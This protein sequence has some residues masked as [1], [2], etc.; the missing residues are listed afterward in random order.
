MGGLSSGVLPGGGRAGRRRR[1]RS[2]LKCVHPCPG[3]AL[4]QI[5]APRRR[6]WLRA[7]LGPWPAATR[8]AG[9]VRGPALPNPISH[10]VWDTA[11]VTAGPILSQLLW[12]GEGDPKVSGADPATLTPR[13]VVGTTGQ[14][15]IFQ[16][17]PTVK[18]MGEKKTESF[19]QDGDHNPNPSI[20][21]L[22]GECEKRQYMKSCNQM[23]NGIKRRK[24]YVTM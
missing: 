19:K 21:M 17:D 12:G 6:P 15:Q 18:L 20:P 9:A 2:L 4:P 10:A 11:Q 22:G 3:Q 13:N 23:S 16:L 1:T 7:L 24:K 14:R 8:G 5:S